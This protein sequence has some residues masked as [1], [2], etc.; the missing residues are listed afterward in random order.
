[1]QALFIAEL[2]FIVFISWLIIMS[3]RGGAT[4]KEESKSFLNK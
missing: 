2:G 4:I 3:N 1:M